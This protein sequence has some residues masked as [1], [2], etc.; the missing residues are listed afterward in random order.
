MATP[1]SFLVAV[2]KAV[3]ERRELRRRW[4]IFVVA[5][6][7][8]LVGVYAF[9]VVPAA[10]FRKIV[11]VLLLVA[12]ATLIAHP[13]IQRWIQRRHTGE[14]R[15]RMGLIVIGIFGTSVYAGFVGGGV[16]VLVL[17]V[18]GTCA[19]WPW[20][21][22]NRLKNLICLATSMVGAGAYTITGFVDWPMAAVLAV[23]LGTGGITGHV[24]MTWLARKGRREDVESVLR[25][26]VMAGASLGAGVMLAG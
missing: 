21:E 11:P 6:V 25:Q 16:G 4:P 20:L 10:G 2:P 26:V 13:W 1:A 19:A 5:V 7:G 15:E 22:A 18:L 12:T 24:L 3:R 23:S 17:I 9:Y 14:Q 8:T